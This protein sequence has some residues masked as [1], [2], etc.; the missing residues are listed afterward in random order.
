MTMKKLNYYY[1]LILCIIIVC[2]F[3]SCS[4]DNDDSSKSGDNVIQSISASISKSSLT[5]DSQFASEQLTLTIKAGSN[6]YWD[7]STDAYWCDIDRTNGYESGT[8]TITVRCSENRYDEDRSATLTLKVFD[9]Q[10]NEKTACCTITQKGKETLTL[11]KS[12]FEIGKAGGYIDIEIRSNIQY[13]Y[14]IEDN[15]KTWIHEST[16]SSTRA[17]VTTSLLHFKIDENEYAKRVGH[18]TI[19][20]SDISET[21]T[22]YQDGDKESIVLTSSDY[23]VSKEGEKLNIV[24]K[25]NTIYEIEKPEVEWIKDVTAQTRAMMTHNHYFEVYPNTESGNRTTKLIIKSNDITEYINITQA[26]K[27]EAEI[28]V[29]VLTPGSLSD[30]ISVDRRPT[31][32]SIKITGT[33]NSSDLKV[34]NDMT[35]LTYLDL[36]D[37]NLGINSLGCDYSGNSWYH[38]FPTTLKYLKLPGSIKRLE[39][40]YRYSDPIWLHHYFGMFGYEIYSYYDHYV[41]HSSSSTHFESIEL[42][43]GTEYIGKLVFFNC[44]LKQINLPNSLTTINGDAPFPESLLRIDIK[45]LNVF[46]KKKFSGIFNKNTT[47]YCNNTLVTSVSIPTS[48]K[49][50]TDIFR[51][52]KY[53]KTISL[54]SSLTSIAEDALNGC[55]N[56][57]SID[58]P[59]SVTTIGTRAFLG[60]SISEMK[61]NNFEHWAKVFNHT[62]TPFSNSNH[63]RL[64]Y[65]GKKVESVEIPSSIAELDGAYSYVEGI[66]EVHCKSTTP[67]KLNTSSYGDFNLIDKNTAIL[68]VPKGTKQKYNL[69]DWGVLFKNI[70]EE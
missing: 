11:T 17:A 4:G 56:L 57:S 19:N 53:L 39:D 21:I 43:E 3:T 2:C 25:S 50:L 14:V 45:D 69:S 12:Q 37:A 20:G 52:Y 42:S 26:G 33:L 18:I 15:A 7:V 49:E 62:N 44:E 34:L 65:N 60:C 9:G 58:I 66:K 10:G 29:N 1:L 22:I 63:G 68:Y 67:V 64:I 59:S 40:G 5:F 38:P 36:K 24:I 27:D 47:L 28:T 8:F 48:M 46:C 51:G 16:S 6:V 61:I 31:I 70:V 54:H 23:Y 13:S 32:N 35:E 30:L 41:T 55:V